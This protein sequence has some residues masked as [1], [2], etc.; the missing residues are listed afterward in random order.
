MA[1]T[2]VV[3]RPAVAGDVPEL[4]RLWEQAS[5]AWRRGE[6]GVLPEA[7][8]RVEARLTDLLGNSDAQVL[9]ATV[10]AEP[11]GMTILT[12]TLLGP[13]SQLPSLQMSYLVVAAGHR[14]RG[15]GHALVGAAAAVAEDRGFEQIL[16][17]VVSTHRESNRFLGRLG[18]APVMA[19]RA[20]SV[21]VLKRRVA[22]SERRPMAESLV[23]RRAVVVAPRQVPLESAGLDAAGLDSA[24]LHAGRLPAGNRAVAAPRTPDRHGAVPEA[25]PPVR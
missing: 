9:V 20:A 4:A 23:R 10:R 5:E 6:R 25:G 13:L 16:V 1:R 17:N 18:F 21:S 15:I 2:A 7:L 19:R 24:G 12:P 14:R 8:A 22:R 3:V 11:V